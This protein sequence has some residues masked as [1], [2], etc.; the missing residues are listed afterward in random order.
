M[1]ALLT[2]C[3]CLAYLPLIAQ[4]EIQGNGPLDSPSDWESQVENQ[5]NA[6]QY[7]LQN[8]LDINQC[9]PE[10]L[11]QLPGMEKEQ[12]EAFLAHRQ[13]ITR[14]ES[15]YELQ[16]IPH[17]DLA[18]CR[19]MAA[20]LRCDPLKSSPTWASAKHFI[21]W[22]LERVLEEKKGF[23]PASKNSKVRYLGNPLLSFFRIKSQWGGSWQWGISLQKDAGEPSWTDFRSAY[24]RYQ[25]K[26]IQWILGDFGMAWSLGL[27]KSRGFFI[28]KS[29]LSMSSGQGGHTGAQA[30]Q[31]AGEFS[32]HRGLYGQWKSRGQGQ[33]EWYLSRRR[34]DA[35]LDTCRC[36]FQ[37]IDADGYHRTATELAKKQNLGWWQG[38]FSHQRTWLGLRWQ[39]NQSWQAYQFPKK[40]SNLSYK[41]HEWSGKSYFLQSLG[42]TY[43]GKSRLWSGEWGHRDYR[44]WAGLLGMM[45]SIN[46][47]W[48]WR[49]VARLYQSGFYNPEGQA[50]SES[51][52]QNEYGLY[53]GSFW[54]INKRRFW[55][56]YL[57]FFLFPQEKYQVSASNTFGWE[58]LSRY[59]ASKKSGKT[60]YAQIK[61][62]RKEQNPSGTKAGPSPL[63]DLQGLGDLLLPQGH[64][65]TWHGRLALHA[66]A[67]N[68]KKALGWGIFGD[69]NHRRRHWNIK[70]RLSY[71]HS[72]AYETRIYAYE[73][74]LRYDFAVPAN[75]GRAIKSITVLEFNCTKQ[76]YL[77]LRWSHLHYFDRNSIGSGL[78]AIQGNKKNEWGLSL[79]YH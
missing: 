44:S 79:I 47:A 19:F 37:S 65:W 2:T 21:L 64:R 45:Q 73:P 77:G 67:Q 36:A 15:I 28:G 40:A 78:E 55:S 51:A 29:Y 11:A 70:Q 48:D 12:L 22:R 69:V 30:Y 6:Y 10:E 59:Q 57:D 43:R 20:F 61:W 8:P 58:W 27:L 62:T 9:L 49:V 41:A 75:E 16:V 72:P 3:L 14:F 25:G 34:L 38:G 33:W 1:K 52:N 23:S 32:F 42:W 76:L 35:S 66:Q 60:W 17:W 56:N 54:Q 50:L 31:S 71:V 46:R 39:I 26:D 18:F 74:Q 5:G 13:A 53:L 4:T 63:H 68:G 7:L 24:L